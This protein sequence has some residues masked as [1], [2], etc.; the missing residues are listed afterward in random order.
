MR[1]E[2]R[3]GQ[4]EDRYACAIGLVQNPKCYEKWQTHMYQLA[5]DEQVE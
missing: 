1:S 3:Q 5:D 2:A 4:R